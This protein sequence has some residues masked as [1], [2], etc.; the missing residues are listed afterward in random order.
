MQ[1]TM[2]EAVQFRIS[3]E[4]DK[5]A[6]TWIYAQKLGIGNPGYDRYAWAIDQVLDLAFHEPNQLWQLIQRIL[7]IDSS[8]KI[9]R[10]LGA[11]P[12]EDLMV[13]HGETLIGEVEARA[14]TSKAFKA[15]M[16]SVW[17]EESD[18]P[19]CKKFFAIAGIAPPS[20]GR[21]KRQVG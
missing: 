16:Q 7:E 5:L 20:R 2:T 6:R 9:V 14:S 17:L 12:L 13:Q 10:A 1:T 8:E 11:G 18:T 15:A 3:Q 4:R 21:A 19:V